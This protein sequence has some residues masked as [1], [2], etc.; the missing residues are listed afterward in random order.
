MS[1]KGRRFGDCVL[2]PTGG[3]FCAACICMK[4]S[5]TAWAGVRIWLP[6]VSVQTPASIIAG[7]I[8]AI[9]S[10]SVGG[11]ILR[12]GWRANRAKGERIV[13]GRRRRQLLRQYD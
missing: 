3:R 9:V 2:S 1:T 6:A 5:Q 8:S 12:V 13:L 4:M 10:S 7:V 11:R